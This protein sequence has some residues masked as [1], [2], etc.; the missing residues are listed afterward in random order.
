MASH[1]ATSPAAEAASADEAT[2]LVRQYC[3]V[4]HNDR[5]LTGGLSLA[6]F[7][8]SAAADNRTVAEKMIRKLRGG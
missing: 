6:S 8:A 1:P 4:C 2:A 3:V 5:R 7:D